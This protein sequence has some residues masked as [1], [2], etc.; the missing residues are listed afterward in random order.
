MIKY[1]IIL[2]SCWLSFFDVS[3]QTSFYKRSKI[4]NNGKI[5]NCSD[6]GHYMTFGNNCLYDSNKEGYQEFGSNMKYIKTDNNIKIYYGPS[7]YGICYCYVSM[8]N[9]RLNLKKDDGVIYV[10]EQC[11]PSS[12]IKR[13]QVSNN[14]SSQSVITN[15]NSVGQSYQPPQTNY[16]NSTKTQKQ[17]RQCPGCN[18]S[19][20]AYDKIT[21][22][23]SYTGNY[24]RE[25]CQKCSSWGNKHYHQNITC[26]VC[27]G[28][29]YIEN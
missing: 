29:R 22:Q 18:G 12:N 25:Y 9:K 26:R 13:R 28:K 8:D 2:C 20:V 24:I 1:F 4:V 7:Y 14:S 6:D 17:S 27:M 10:Y 15:P 5:S 23:T 19:G 21:Y 11:Q 3:A 16:N